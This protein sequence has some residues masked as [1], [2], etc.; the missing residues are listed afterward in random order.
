MKR[1][2]PFFLFT[3]LAE[4]VLGQ[5][6]K[7]KDAPKPLSPA[8]S[9]NR[10]KVPAG[11]RLEMIAAEPLIRQPSGMCWDERGRLFVCEL[12]GY[13]LEGQFDIEELN[14]TGKLDRVVRRLPAG[15]EAMRKAE[16]S[17]Y[18]TV[19]QLIDTDGDGRMDKAMVWADRLPPC[20]GICPARGGVIVVCA[21]DIVFLADRDGDGKAE[22]REKLFTG[23]TEVILE[24]R[25]NSPR[26][27]LDNWIYV[28]RGRGGRITGPRLRAAVNLPATDFRFKADGSDIEPINGGTHTFGFAFN[29]DG[30]RFT[31]STRTPGIQVAP[32]PWR[33]LARNPDV[34]IRAVERNAAG[35]QRVFPT[36][37][38]HPWREKRA[39][40]PGFSKYYRDRYGA[41]ESAPNGYFTSACSPLIYQD[42]AIPSLRGQLLACAPAQN[43]IHRAL[44]RRDGAR[45]TLHRA[46]GEVSSEFLPSRDIWFHPIHLTHGPA[47][48]VW[49]ADFYR[50]I[51]EDYS[52]IPRYLQQQY[53][54]KDGENHGRLW[55]L[56]HHKMLMAP[57]PNLARLDAAPLAH[58]VSSPHYW[59]RQTARR[60]FVERGRADKS[61]LT[62]LEK[63]AAEA[64]DPAGAINALYTLDGLKRLTAAVVEAALAHREPG[65]RRHALR[66]AERRFG[67][68]KTLLLTVIKMV[69]D[70]S[71]IVRLQ[72]ALTLGESTDP[73][74]TAALAQ[75]A[76]RHG[77]D[78]WLND[79]VLSSLGGR[80]GGMLAALLE[81]PKAAARVRGLVGRLCTTVASRQNAKEF[82]SA[83]VRVA[84]LKDHDLQRLC[85]TGFRAPFKSTTIVALSKPA[86]G[87]LKR[88]TMADDAGLRATALGLMRVLKLE[89]AAERTARMDAA[90]R[91]AGDVKLSVARRLAAVRG[92]SA[93][94]DTAIAARLLKAF[95]TATPVVRRAIL[96]TAFARRGHLPAV[97]A[98]LEKK[99]LPTAAL[100]AIHRTTLLQHPDTAL[101]NRAAVLLKPTRPVDKKTLQQFLSA[102][103]EPRNVAN[104]AKVHRAHCAICHRAHGVGF[105]VGPDLAAEF[106]R[107]EETIVRDILAP[108]EMIEVGHETW[109][110]ETT[111]GRALSGLLA[112]ESAGSLTLSLPGGKLLDVLRKDIKSV[113]P[114]SVSLMPGTLAQVL[115]PRDVADVIAWL[116]RP[117]SRRVLFDDDDTFVKSLIDGKGT[118][119]I[120]TNDKHNGTAA[121]RITP[122]QKHSAQIKGWAFRIRQNPGPSEYRYLRWAWKAPDAQGA[123]IELADK[124]K[125]PSSDKPT[126]RYY[127][128][129]NTTTWKATLVSVHSPSEWKVVT[130]D[131]WEDFGNFT[132]T[133]IAPTAMGGPV[134]FDQIELLRRLED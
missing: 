10:F 72:L 97:V 88:L 84:R 59:R 69:E 7:P 56:A 87:A 66:L 42:I 46:P 52:A 93:E 30:D 54:L 29:A 5:I 134:L 8:E 50:E 132:L 110:I 105:A 133:G 28:G 25:M 98:A 73:R 57:L 18:G 124:G 41:A 67:E 114:L 91:E 40:D 14:K 90:L 70:K 115:K 53:G 24:R 64:K 120:V 127:S 128:G 106:R 65:V 58:E 78:E 26:W 102:L 2:L 39:A 55:R 9:A 86:S 36:S 34:S 17:Q 31:I 1:L 68:N 104:G 23:F 109:V 22:V 107:A 96:E 20:F 130:R 11:F 35:Y 121:L 122:P 51:I 6:P 44:I 15:L 12:H 117:P 112:T 79:A 37:H 60:L 43:F 49:I 125:W 61:A 21:P 48:G 63:T 16:A 81:E 103:N 131:L 92:L 95:P 116:R 19:K 89:S 82:S 38:A 71:A 100:N 126:R 99:Q 3:I 45:L 47:G 27:G 119:Q 118:A 83:L 123:M 13:N 74:A 108:S 129:K 94:N 85:L 4:A 113:K 33:Y 62:V 76:T 75:L 111:D 77:G 101:R 80:A 32:L